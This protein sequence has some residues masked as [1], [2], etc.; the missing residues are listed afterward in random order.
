MTAGDMTDRQMSYATT[1]P[2]T[3]M[4]YAEAGNMPSIENFLNV[5]TN[6]N[7]TPQINVL[8]DNNYIMYQDAN[9][10]QP[11]VQQQVYVA[12][13]MTTEL[14]QEAENLCQMQQQP[15]Q[16]AL[17]DAG[18]IYLNGA[19]QQQAEFQIPANNN[20]VFYPDQNQIMYQNYAGQ[21]P[22]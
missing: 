22:Q 21:F 12:P 18:Q 10:A 11:A 2:S 15:T 13:Q 6:Q 9:Y 17:Q 4:Q 7:Q 3:Q 5:M 20:L 14:W 1:Q 19:I 16:Y 8:A